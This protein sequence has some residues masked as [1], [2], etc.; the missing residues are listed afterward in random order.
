MHTTKNKF[1]VISLREIAA[2]RVRYHRPSIE[3]VEEYIEELA[4]QNP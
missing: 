4:K 3:V 2:G 1:S